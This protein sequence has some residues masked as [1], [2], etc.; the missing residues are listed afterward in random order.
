MVGAPGTR[1]RRDHHGM[2]FAGGKSPIQVSGCHPASR[3]T[4]HVRFFTR[5]KAITS[6][7]LDPIRTGI[8]LGFPENK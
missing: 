7:R 2:P 4:D 6:R 5:G 3:Q 8:N 1:R